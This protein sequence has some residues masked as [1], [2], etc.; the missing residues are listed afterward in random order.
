MMTQANIALLR[1]QRPRRTGLDSGFSLLEL[2][3]VMTV[4]SILASVL[5]PSM[6]KQLHLAATEREDQDLRQISRALQQNI[7]RTKRIPDEDSW[8]EAVAGELARNPQEVLTNVAHGPRVYLIDPALRIGAADSGLP[9]E[10][11]EQGS[12]KPVSPRLL[13]VSSLNPSK[14]LPVASGVVDADTFTNLWNASSGA[15]PTGWTDW[16]NS[17]QDLR[18]ER[19]NLEP[20]FERL[21]LN[22]L[23]V[24]PSP[25][26]AIDGGESVSVSADGI[27][28]YFLRGSHL[29]LR[30]A[31]DEAD[32]DQLLL[33]S[34]A[35]CFS[36][37]AWQRRV[38]SA[39][40]GNE[41]YFATNLLSGATTNPLA[42][43][44]STT[45]EVI[46]A[47][48]DYMNAY[49]AWDEAGFPG[50]GTSTLSDVQ[51]AQATLATLAAGLID[52]SDP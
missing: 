14:T 41:A 17:A 7:L 25:Y 49:V 12:I 33:K 13:I 50:L 3:G 11:G 42:D 38:S 23:T 46:D 48:T 45:A 40:P 31:S 35:Y 39:G 8:A 44:G 21:I 6:I 15:A 26:Y 36:D 47:M 5:M 18:I 52:R 1:R 24:G 10:Q 16:Q 34:G 22:N 19:L 29:S 43:A 2:V 9:Y 28:A 37:G 51:N 4:M 27:D 20:L 32:S 30:T